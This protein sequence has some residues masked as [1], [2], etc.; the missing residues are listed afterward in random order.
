MI[1]T[2]ALRAAEPNERRP[3]GILWFL[4]LGASLWVF[5]DALGPKLL[6]FR[7]HFLLF[8]RL[9]FA[10]AEAYREGRWPLWDA[11]AG[12]GTPLLADPNSLALWPPLALL[13]LPFDLHQLYDVMIYGHYVLGFFGA[14]GLARSLGAS[15]SGASLG[16][17]TFAL[18]GPLLSFNNLCAHVAG[19]SVAPLILFLAI[20]VLDRPSFG[21]VSVL[22][23]VL[24]LAGP[25]SDPFFILAEFLCFVGLAGHR[26]RSAPKKAWAGLGAAAVL[27]VGL[28]AIQIL[29]R[30]EL[31]LDGARGAGLAFVHKA[32]HSVLPFRTLEAFL[33]G[34]AG[35]QWSKRIV[36]TSDGNELFLASL[37]LGASLAGVFAVGARV[38]QSRRA[39]GLLL[40]FALLSLGRFLP[41]YELLSKVP[42]LS[43]AR[44]PEKLWL[45][46]AISA[47]CCAALAVTAVESE[48][49]YAASLRRLAWLGPVLVA[50][51]ALSVASWVP[52]VTSAD[53]ISGMPVEVA[54]RLLW[55]S[56]A[57]GAFF[58][59]AGGAALSYWLRHSQAR[60][61]FGL[62]FFVVAADLAIAGRP[63][64]PAGPPALLARP[65][66]LERI[67]RH[68]ESPR[69][70]LYEEH[71][72]PEAPPWVTQLDNTLYTAQR[73][74]PGFGMMN[75]VSYSLD[76][77]YDDFRSKRWV[78]FAEQFSK[79]DEPGR[80]RL[81][82]RLGADAMLVEATGES[83]FG[84]RF[85]D[86]VP[87]WRGPPLSIFAIE[88]TRPKVGLATG[89]IESSDLAVLTS[90]APTVAVVSPGAVRLSPP[91]G[92]GRV[93]VDLERSGL[94]ELSVTADR[95]A[96]LVVTQTFDPGWRA[97]VDELRV[98][99]VV[100]DGTLIGVP[101]PEGT[102]LVRLEYLP[103]SFRLG[104]FMSAGATALL[105][106][107]SIWSRRRTRGSR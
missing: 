65:P 33:P 45:G 69:I 6:F 74:G 37:Y 27:A 87:I 56:V 103:E 29:P 35:E 83:F 23:V 68:F 97:T 95:P 91:L 15:R 41:G 94:L 40:L 101:V 78:S 17:L 38:E 77:D 55:R 24:G 71:R 31:I 53:V 26:L 104:R 82:A 107:L 73:L 96:L 62:L 50:V 90:T 16:G 4:A 106:V 2:I 5:A 80:L 36:F 7:D 57:H 105:L 19:S 92:E 93:T 1:S 10:V 59:V 102:H 64:V 72:G 86:R 67:E 34:L 81:L 47:A 11:R 39:F 13:W 42:L 32:R 14:F 79:A 70:F 88:N 43:S 61:P 48:P 49:A 3:F 60:G 9:T 18:S 51:A 20:R 76:L 22:A 46:V 58:S 28:G 63:V 100:V 52:S 84:L 66:A 44:Y 21:R 99:A 54:R 98:D 25:I 85:L 30:A 89:I 75:G 12:N 8:R